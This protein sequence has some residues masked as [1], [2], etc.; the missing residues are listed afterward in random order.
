MEKEIG[1]ILEVIK[2]L[3]K[4]CMNLAGTLFVMGKY[5]LNENLSCMS[6]M[7]YEGSDISI[8]GFS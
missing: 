1:F 2:V 5:N 7:K 3:A 6:K 8:G 4:S